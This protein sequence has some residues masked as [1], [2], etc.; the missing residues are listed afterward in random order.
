M[1]VETFEIDIPDADLTE[2]RERL[3]ATRW[4]GPALSAAWENGSDLSFMQRLAAHWRDGFDWR[5]QERRLNALSQYVAGLDG[6]DVHFIHARG[7][8]AAPMPLVL[9]H[10][11]PGSFLEFEQILPI[12]RNNAIVLRTLYFDRESLD[13]LCQPSTIEYFYPIIYNSVGEGYLALIRSLLETRHLSQAQT[14]LKELEAWVNTHPAEKPFF[15][16]AQEAWKNS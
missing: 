12:Y 14:A 9:T 10:G 7:E 3:T 11:W 4:P 8:G 15:E 16:Q 13:A 2:L 5:A 1:K 6:Q